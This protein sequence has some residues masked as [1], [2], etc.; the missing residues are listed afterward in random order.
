MQG[1]G[2]GAGDVL[3]SLRLTVRVLSAEL[4]C[5]VAWFFLRCALPLVPL[6][7][8]GLTETTLKEFVTILWPLGAFFL[9]SS[10]LLLRKCIAVGG[11]F[12]GPFTASVSYAIVLRIQNHF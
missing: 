8:K 11:S 12:W 6:L 10:R 2:T 5:L 1:G 4:L 7:M 3:L 9:G